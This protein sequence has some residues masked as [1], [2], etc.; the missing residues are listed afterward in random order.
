MT[1][2]SRSID[3]HSHTRFSD[4]RHTPA[5]MAKHAAKLGYTLGISDHIDTRKCMASDKDVMTYYRAIADLPVYR[6]AEVSVE[7]KLAISTEILQQFDYLIVSVHTIDGWSIFS[8][9]FPITDPDTVLAKHIDSLAAFL[10]LNHFDILGHPTLTAKPFMANPQQVWTPKRV[11]QLIQVG[12][13]HDLA[14]ELNARSMTPHPEFVH[15]AL[16]MGARFAV[17]TDAHRYQ[18]LGK[19]SYPY[20]LIDQFD[21]PDNRIFIPERKVHP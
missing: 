11:E 4:G 12:M 20:Q 2:T 14:F 1:P 16:E 15:L 3:I 21:I 8:G 6:S 13:T 9:N 7:D 19:L 5:E 18:S 10:E 17:G